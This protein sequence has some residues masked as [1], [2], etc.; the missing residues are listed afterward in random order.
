M[1]SIQPKVKI[2]SPLARVPAYETSG[3]AAM[4][5]YPAI[6]NSVVVAPNCTQLVPTG[7][8]IWIESFNACAMIL[9]RS[10]LG[11]KNGIILGNGTGLI[12]CDYQGEWKISVHNRSGKIFRIEP[13]MRIAQVVFVPVLKAEF[14]IVDNFEEQTARG[15]GGFG[16]TGITDAIA[17]Q[18]VG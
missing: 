10:G 12:D 4:D 16:S 8:H 3:S 9:P 15:E 7:L 11:H 14:E 13:D 5:L 6:E 17:R 2:V 1:I 18:R